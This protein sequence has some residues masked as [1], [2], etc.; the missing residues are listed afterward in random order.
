MFRRFEKNNQNFLVRV[1]SQS[2]KEL[3][4]ANEPEQYICVTRKGVTLSLR[5]VN[6]VLPSGET[7]KLVTNLPDDF[8][9]DNLAQLYGK[10]WGIE[11]NYLF[12]KRKMMVEIFIGETVTAVLQDFHASVHHKNY[13]PSYNSLYKSHHKIVE[14]SSFAK[15]FIKFFV[16][17]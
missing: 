1:S 4:T 13:Q 16:V 2:L 12:L 11:T 15:D 8:S 17:F 9:V 5:V 10:R 3:N 6:V 14:K 7:E